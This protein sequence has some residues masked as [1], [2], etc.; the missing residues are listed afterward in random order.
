MKK[1]TTFKVGEHKGTKYMDEFKKPSTSDREQNNK[2]IRD[3]W[4]FPDKPLNNVEDQEKVRK[5]ITLSFKNV[6]HEKSG[7]SNIPPGGLIERVSVIKI[8]STCADN[9]GIEETLTPGNLNKKFIC[10][11]CKKEFNTNDMFVVWS[12]KIK[13]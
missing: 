11:L 7:R 9:Q 13:K 3:R 10:H 6:W 8:C 1:G 5:G 12:D 2:A 4:P